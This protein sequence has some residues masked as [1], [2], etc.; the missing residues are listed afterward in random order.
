MVL[1]A[2]SLKVTGL[3]LNQSGTHHPLLYD[4]PENLHERVKYLSTKRSSGGSSRLALKL[5][6]TAL[7]KPSVFEAIAKKRRLYIN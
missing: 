6:A 5:E 1:E 2:T 3:V 4:T 7:M